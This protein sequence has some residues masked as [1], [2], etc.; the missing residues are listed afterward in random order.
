[1]R[2]NSNPSAKRKKDGRR[3]KNKGVKDLNGKVTLRG[4]SLASYPFPPEDPFSRA[5]FT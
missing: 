4:Q 1:V 5:I 3:I 2:L